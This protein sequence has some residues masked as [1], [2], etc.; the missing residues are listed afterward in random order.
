MEM[1][2]PGPSTSS[3]T[4]PST[5]GSGKIRIGMVR[6]NKSGR[7]VRAIRETGATTRPMARAPSGM[8]TEINTRV[9]GL[10]TK[11][12]DTGPTHTLMELNIRAI[13]RTICSMVMVS[14][15]GPTALVM[16][17]TMSRAGSTDTVPTPGKM[18]RNTRETGLKTKFTAAEP[19]SGLMV[20]N[21]RANGSTTTCTATA[22]TPGRMGV[23]MRASMRRIAST[24]TA[25]I[26]GPMVA[27]T[28]ASG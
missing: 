8:S 3:R 26:C 10:M 20:A 5:L 27:S 2:R 18:G 22:F 11:P 13:G 14:R 21:T 1:L 25:F 16:K 19:T 9:A 28:M 15:S 6:A 24:A 12:T 4:G 23:A 7:M 17:A